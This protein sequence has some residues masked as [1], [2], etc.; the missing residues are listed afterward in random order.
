M[1]RTSFLFTFAVLAV[2]CAASGQEP[3]GIS[4]DGGADADQDTGELTLPDTNPPDAPGDTVVCVS[5]TVTA[6][7]VP[8]AMLVLI[9]RSGSMASGSKWESATK[10]IR[11][12]ADRAD[13]V[14]MKMGLQFFPPT[15]TGVDTCNASVYKTLAVPMKALPENVLP[16]ASK[17]D[18]T[19]ANGGATPMRSGLEG[20]IAALRDFVAADPDHEPAVILVTDGDPTSCGAISTVASVASNGATPPPG[21]PRVRTFVVGMDGATFANLDTVAAAGGTTKAYDVGSGPAASDALAKALDEIRTGAIGCEYA[22]PDVGKDRRLDYDSVQVLFTPGKGDPTTTF[23][24]VASVDACGE[25]TGG[26]YYDDPADPKR[27]K[28]CDASCKAVRAGTAS[29]KVEVFLGCIEV[30]K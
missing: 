22:I 11:G 25:T 30:I 27:I 18:A 10:A 3:I 20:S 14:G 16:I 21:I 12:F 13:V 23:N 9:D 2:G 26:Y 7:P 19:D 6:V 17:L 15:T 24:K 1:F 8:L 5:D 4:L 28:L 29:A